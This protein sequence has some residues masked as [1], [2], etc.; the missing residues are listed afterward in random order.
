MSESDF[1]A[2]VADPKVVRAAGVAG[3][4]AREFVER[5]MKAAGV[6]IIRKKADSSDR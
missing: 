3:V 2:M 4:T 6:R 1:D 5:L